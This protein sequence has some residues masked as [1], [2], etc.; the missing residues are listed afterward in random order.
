MDPELISYLEE[1]SEDIPLKY[2]ILIRFYLPKEMRNK[3]QEHICKAG[4]KN[5][6]LYIIKQLKKEINKSRK[7]LYTYTV[8]GFIFLLAAF[9]LQKFSREMVLLILFSEGLFIGGTLIDSDGSVEEI[10]SDEYTVNITDEW[11]SPHTDI[12]YPSGWDI[13][14]K[15]I[16]LIVTPIL[17][18]QELAFTH[19]NKYWEGACIVE[20]D[21]TGRAYVELVSGIYI[22]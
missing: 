18:D 14:V 5:Y 20:G 4:L 9:S 7:S 12:T 17:K 16:K 19:Y 6:F 1:C 8:T 3:E 2:A 13:K 21:I 11:I 10:K 22:T 15:D